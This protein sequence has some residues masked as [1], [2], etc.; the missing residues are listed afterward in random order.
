MTSS[1]KAK[2]SETK[3]TRYLITQ[4]IIL[5]GIFILLFIYRHSPKIILLLISLNSF[6]W[7]YISV[8]IWKWICL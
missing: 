1:F 4:I 5:I 8:K 6:N 7:I 3:F 2:N